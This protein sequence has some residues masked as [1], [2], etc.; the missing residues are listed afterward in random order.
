MVK[1]GKI[2]ETSHIRR[3]IRKSYK[4]SKKQRMMIHNASDYQEERKPLCSCGCSNRQHIP[5]IPL[6]G[7]NR[8]NYLEYIGPA[9]FIAITLGAAVIS[10]YRSNRNHQDDSRNRSQGIAQKVQ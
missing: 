1:F 7:K 6:T 4:P 9:I 10:M 8:I 5:D 3:L 2:R